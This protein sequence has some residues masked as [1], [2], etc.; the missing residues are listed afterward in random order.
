MIYLTGMQKILELRN[1]SKV[2]DDKAGKTT[3]IDEISLSIEKG[4]IYGIIGLSGAGK[5][6]LIRCINRLEEPNTG[7]ILFTLSDG[8][9]TDI[10][11]LKGKD[12]MMVRKRIAMIFQSFNLFQQRNAFDNVLFP[13]ETFHRLSEKKRRRIEAKKEKTVFEYLS[14]EMDKTLPGKKEDKEQRAREL[15][16]LVGLSDK[17]KSYPSQ[18]SGGQQQRVAIARALALH[19]DILLSDESTSALDPKTTQS[20]LKLLKDIN[21]KTGLTI[22][23]ITHQMSVIEAICNKVAIIDKSHIVEEGF[24]KDVFAH[25]KSE[26]ARQLLYTD[27]INTNLSPSRQIRLFFDGNSDEPIVAL[28]IEECHTLVNILYA[29]TKVLDNKTYGQMVL[30][31]PEFDEDIEKVK[32]FLTKKG[33]KYQLVLD[34]LFK[35]STQRIEKNDESKP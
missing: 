11:T 33:V 29:D 5:S 21:Q 16:E 4:D 31:L 30:Q 23:L 8:K 20:I 22:I 27:R 32:K 35:T 3:A 24:M 2:Y 13:L 1:L 9:E 15:L 12:L 6:T 18:L 10:A 26:I 7:Q 19:P 14:L 25:P 34:R 17:E 28:M